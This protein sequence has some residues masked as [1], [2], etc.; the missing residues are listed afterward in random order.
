LREVRKCTK[1]GTVAGASTPDYTIKE[2]IA[3]MSDVALENK[4]MTMEELLQSDEFNKTL[5][6]PRN[7][8]IRQP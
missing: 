7:G 3:N 1:I 2:V 5:K 4:E 8:E 6:L